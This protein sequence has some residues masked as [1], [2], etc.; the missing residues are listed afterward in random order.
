MNYRNVL[1]STFLTIL[2]YGMKYSFLHYVKVKTYEIWN[3][4]MRVT[5]HIHKVNGKRML[6][7]MCWIMTNQCLTHP[8]YYLLCGTCVRCVKSGDFGH[9]L[10]IIVVMLYLLIFLE[11][12]TSLLAYFEIPLSLDQSIIISVIIIR[13]K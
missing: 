10:C 7:Y 12:L 1:H 11:L 5:L 6:C 13:M 2:L 8:C 9:F 3:E 4:I